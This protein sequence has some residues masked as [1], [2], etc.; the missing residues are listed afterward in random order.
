MAKKEQLFVVRHSDGYA[1]K[2][3]NAQRA[4]YVARTQQDAIDRAVQMAK[5]HGNAEVKIQGKDG[6]WRSSDTYGKDPC[7]PKDKE[8]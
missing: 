7:P 3:A 1:V 6:R 8:H 5:Q 2:R 4:S